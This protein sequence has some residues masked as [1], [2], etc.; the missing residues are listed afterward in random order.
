[1]GPVDAVFNHPKHPYTQGLLASVISVDTTELVSIDGTPPDLVN[2]P[3]GCRFWPRC[4]VKAE[5]SDRIDPALTG[6][7]P[8]HEA[9]CLLYEGAEVGHGAGR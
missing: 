4:P 3:P 5:G 8:G 7:G 1:M 6:V 2:P 9:A